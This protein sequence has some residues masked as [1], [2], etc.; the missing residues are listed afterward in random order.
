MVDLKLKN[1]SIRNWMKFHHVQVEFPEKGLVLVQGVNTASG[2]ALLSVGSGKTGIGEAISRTLLGV[3]GRFT[4]LKQFST[5]KNGNL[6]VKLEVELRGKT[7]IVES[8]Y[9]CKEMSTSGEA[10]RYTYDGKLIE[11]GLIA[12]TR[13]E[14][15]KLLGVSPLLASWTAFIDGDSI[16]FNKLGQADSV[17]LVMASL[18]QPPW[19][20]YHESSKKAL[21]A[22]RRSMAGSEATHTNAAESVR[23]VTADVDVAKRQLATE[24][25]VFEQAK[26]A[27]D[28]QI[29]RFKRAVN[30]KTQLIDEAKTEMEAI[31]K[32]L[33]LMEDQR[34]EA[35]H[36]LEIKL[37]EVDD[38][39]RAAEEARQPFSDA[40]DAAN[41]KVT[42]ARTAHSNYASAAKEC[43]TCKRPMGQIDEKRL[44]YLA[45]QLAKAKAA[46]QKASEA[47][48]AAEQKVV[49]LNVQYREISKQ[50]REVSAKQDVEN[51]ADRHEEL[52]E[53]VNMAL[54]EIHEYELEAAKLQSGPSDS[55]VKTAEGRLTDRKAALAKAQAALDEAAHAL[56]ADQATLKILEYWNLAFS[57]YGIPNMVLRDAIAPLNKEARRVSAAM[58]GGTIEVRYSTTRELASGLEK[59]QLNIEVDN[60]LGDKDLGGSSKGEAGLT[61][62]IIAETLSEVGQVSSRVGYR[63]YDEIVPHQDPRVCHSIYS[64][65]K[66]AAHRLGIVIFLVDHNPVAAN[67]ADHVLI[68]EK[69]GESGKVAST[70]RWR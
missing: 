59:A 68:V 23:T 16:K 53:G 24:R 13:A 48:T 22:F 31:Q 52:N 50:H 37:H 27:N 46:A 28:D 1:V 64:Y 67:Y 35:S 40:R 41:E 42:E 14:L 8:G 51:L 33:K 66:E 11:R 19:S 47:W 54:N 70:V 45:E 15:S 17:E 62:F 49:T 6:Y 43:P 10:L 61:N 12:Q 38:A 26:Q 7:L 34:A 2:G 18:K 20:E 9:K 57:P 36:N 69:K 58:T 5:D 63:W 25:K 29:Q 4:T 32:K 3:P 39:L 44:A 21:G 56:A 55:A 60:K 65:M 30:K